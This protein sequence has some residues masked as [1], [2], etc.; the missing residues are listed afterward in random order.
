MRVR[1]KM[2][3]RNHSGKIVTF[4]WK[5]YHTDKDLYRALWK[6]CYNIELKDNNTPN[7]NLLKFITTFGK[8]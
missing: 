5:D 7:E 6:I 8:S 2:F 3:I 1:C 4:N